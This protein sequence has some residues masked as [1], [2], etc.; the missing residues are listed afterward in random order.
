MRIA[1]WHRL[2]VMGVSG[3]AGVF[4]G[5]CLWQVISFLA[6]VLGLFLGGW[7]FAC[8]QEPLVGWVACRTRASRP[9]AVAV[10]ILAV[11]VALIIVGLLVAPA[12]ERD[13]NSSL[14]DLPAQ[15]DATTQRAVALEDAA[16][17][18]LA[19]HDVA[20]HVDLASGKALDSL[21]QRRIGTPTDPTVALGEAVETMGRLGMMLLLSVFF[22][23]GGPQVAEQV[24]STFPGGARSEVRFVL[25]TVHDSF[26]GFARAQ[27]LQSALFGIG[28][29][30]CLAAAG[31]E[32]APLMA[33]FAGV[34]LLVPVVGAVFAIAIPVV[35]T[36][37]WN[38]AALL[39]VG[40]LLVLLEQLVL[41]VVGPRLM[42][43][44][45]GLPP[46]LVLFGLLAGGQVAGFWGAVFG[47]PVL[48]TLL[49]CVE[50]FRPRWAR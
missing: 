17:H 40:I 45:T 9:M 31:V 50:H 16:N 2:A 4:L 32:A 23:L 25:S 41:N 48:A 14:T 27:L 44:Q 13:A 10:T 5:W 47:I 1:D 11:C 3:S 24:T 39:V 30:A 29:W 6:P 8:L 22:L 37:L 33:A 26:E 43:H 15:L 20:F 38:P 12:L 18:W 21:V 19:E 42:S 36:V 35:A 49:T 34:M 46:L 28:V 7:L